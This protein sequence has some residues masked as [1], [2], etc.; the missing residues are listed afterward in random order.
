M[1]ILE[2]V[3]YSI[4]HFSEI[5]VDAGIGVDARVDALGAIDSGRVTEIRDDITA[6]EAIPPEGTNANATPA[7]SGLQ[8]LD[9]PVPITQFADHGVQ[10][11]RKIIE[12][13]QPPLM[14]C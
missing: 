10:I 1:Q 14:P 12:R 8:S 3:P 5:L 4:G 2:D 7:E 9:G 13:F 6:K 11:I